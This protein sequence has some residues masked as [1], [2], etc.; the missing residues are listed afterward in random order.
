MKNKLFLGSFMILL[1]G[2]CT[3][4]NVGTPDSLNTAALPNSVASFATSYV[5]TSSDNFAQYVDNS[6]YGVYNDAWGTG[7]NNSQTLN[8]SSTTHWNVV[9]NQPTGG[10]SVKTYPHSTKQ[11]SKEI[12]S[13]H[14]CSSS[15]N[16]SVPSSW[17]GDRA[18]DVW[19][20]SSDKYEIMIWM[21][22]NNNFNPLADAYNG[23]GAVPSYTNV[24]VGGHT[25]NVYHKFWSSTGKYVF[26]FVRTANTNSGTVDIKAIL[27]WIKNTPKWM[28]D[29]EL[30]RIEFGFEIGSGSGTWT[31][32]S[33][34]AT[35]N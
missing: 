5:Y 21:G 32:N 27:N 28:G 1:L 10:N 16:Y 14:T 6:G 11:V 33:F 9:T 22:R 24:N 13:L 17:S 12:S 15:F 30:N 8:V 18:Y 31:V 19:A 3:K 7:T 35:V 29:E 2:A 26:S 4:E 25:F 23:S 20:G 34:S